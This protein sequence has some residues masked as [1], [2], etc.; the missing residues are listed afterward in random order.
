M[1][2]KYGMLISIIETRKKPWHNDKLSTKQQ[3]F[4]GLD[5]LRGTKILAE[6]A[7]L[8]LSNPQSRGSVGCIP[9]NNL[10]KLILISYTSTANCNTLLN[11][12]SNT[13]HY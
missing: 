7:F 2:Q 4:T 10:R 1:R 5:F 11:G 9:K 8:H 6:C 3:A 13:I 12:L